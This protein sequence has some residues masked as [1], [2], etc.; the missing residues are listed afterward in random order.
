MYKKGIIKTT[1]YYD[2]CSDINPTD[3]ND[4][5]KFKI[6]RSQSEIITPRTKKAERSYDINLFVKN[7][8][9]DISP[10]DTNKTSNI[11]NHVDGAIGSPELHPSIMKR[12]QSIDKN[13]KFI[14]QFPT[15]QPN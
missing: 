14:E 6:H 11:L 3:K 1:S 5:D 2:I 8:Y 4:I 12:K 7:L 10:K 15:I 9:T 13:N